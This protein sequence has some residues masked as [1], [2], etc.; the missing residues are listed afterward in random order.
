MHRFLSSQKNIRLNFG[1]VEN[2]STQPLEQV[3]IHNIIKEMMNWDEFNKLTFYIVNSNAPYDFTFDNTSVVFLLSNENHQI[4]DHVLKAK[5][6]CSPYCPIE[7]LPRNCLPIPLGYN[8]SVLSLPYLSMDR[9]PFTIFFSG[10]LH[11][12]RVWFFLHIQVYRK[13]K[14]L[15][16]LILKQKMEDKIQFTRKFTGG[17]APKEYSETLMNSK[18][19]CVPEGYISDV[20]FRFFEAAMSG[21][22][23]ITK[24]LYNYWFFKDFPGIQINSWWKLHGVL[25]KLDNN[26]PLLEEISR[27]T[28]K[29]YEQNCSEKAVAHKI[30]E[31]LKTLDK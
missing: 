22:V 23:I 16:N 8:G 17:L 21:N 3:Y 5:L 18:I 20:S 7:N 28:L 31:T 30:I 26:L 15:T 27:S 24:R 10:N 2:S 13:L 19:A 6:V 9:R 1:A 14:M 29:Y 11:R 12:R 25:K 4:P